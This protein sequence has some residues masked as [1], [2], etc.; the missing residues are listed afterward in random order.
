MRL[1]VEKAAL[2]GAGA[3]DAITMIGA[4][5]D[6]SGGY[7]N[8]DVKIW[9]S[10]TDA[11]TTGT[12]MTIDAGAKNSYTGN[13]FIEESSGF[14]GKFYSIYG[15]N[16]TTAGIT[17]C[18]EYAYSTDTA[19]SRTSAPSPGRYSI[20]NMQ[21]PALQFACAGT[22]WSSGTY[23]Y[24]SDV[25]AYAFASDSWTSKAATPKTVYQAW[26]NCMFSDD[27]NKIY[28]AMGRWRSGG[29]WYGLDEVR[30]YSISGDSYTSITDANLSYYENSGQWV[31][32][33]NKKMYCPFGYLEGGAGEKNKLDLTYLTASTEAWALATASP[34]RNR[35][36]ATFGQDK[37][38]GYYS[39]GQENLESPTGLV[40]TGGSY[41]MTTDTW[42]TGTPADESGT[43][44]NMG[45]SGSFS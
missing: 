29:T 14:D 13:N 22:S 17:A 3:S 35:S 33:V 45:V 41:D 11:W 18:G 37:S 43:A 38:K 30:T 27:T 24:Y 25:D 28:V 20:G 39:G 34:A 5:G 6:D 16:T 15:Y 12:D 23:S 44:R 19:A 9:D 1:G 40:L 7:N 2:M 8:R 32:D 42:A 21:S 10:S 4:G 31:D 26:Y 36:G